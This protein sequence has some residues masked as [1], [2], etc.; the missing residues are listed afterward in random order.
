L[1]DLDKTDLPNLDYEP[2]IALFSGQKGLDLF[3]KTIEQIID[4]NLYFDLLYFELDPRNVYQAQELLLKYD[5]FSKY[6]IKVLI[7]FMGRSRTLVLDI[8]Y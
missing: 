8:M 4:F 7:D 1:P 6:N 3:L 2:E 5:Y